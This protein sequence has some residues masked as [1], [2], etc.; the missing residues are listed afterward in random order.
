[1]AKM[2]KNFSFVAD[3]RICVNSIKSCWHTHPRDGEDHD[4]RV[5][6][7]LSCALIDRTSTL[8]R[9]NLHGDARN[10]R[11]NFNLTAS[12]HCGH[13]VF[14]RSKVS[15]NILDPFTLRSNRT[16]LVLLILGCVYRD[17]VDSVEEV[18]EGSSHIHAF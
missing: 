16:H 7:K 13:K 8:L 14:S 12:C 1:M 15:T 4:L 18:L 10:A 17:V 6:E 2:T 5:G 11:A 3:I 9:G